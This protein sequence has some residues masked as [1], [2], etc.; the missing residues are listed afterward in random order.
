MPIALRSRAR[1]SSGRVYPSR[2]LMRIHTHTHGGEAMGYY[3]VWV[4][5]GRTRRARMPT[6]EAAELEASILQESGYRAWVQL[7]PNGRS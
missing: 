4:I 5:G 2:T 6:R 3:L 1:L 7:W